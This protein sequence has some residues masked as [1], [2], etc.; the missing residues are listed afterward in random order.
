MH[1]FGRSSNGG[2]ILVLLA[3]G[4]IAAGVCFAQVIT[5]TLFGRITDP[6]GA[7]VPGVSLTAVNT[8][9]GREFTATTDATGNYSFLNL[10]P[11]EYTLK[12]E[13]SGFTTSTTHGIVLVVDQK[14][15]VDVALQVGQ[16]TA[17]VNVS[18][19]APVIDTTTASVGT[20]VAGQTVVA[21]PLNLR[22]YGSLALLSP[23]TVNDNGGFAS[24]TEGS[25]FAVSSYSANGSRT[26]SNNYLIDGVDARAVHFGSF[27]IEPDPDAIEEFKVQTNVYDAAFGTA[28]GSTIN[29]VTKSGTN[30]FH[31]TAYEFLRNSDMDSRNFFSQNQ[32]NIVTGQ[33]EPGTARAVLKRNQFGAAVGGP[34]RK[35]KTFFFGNYEGLRLIEGDVQSSLVPSAAEAQGNFGALLTGTD[36]NLCGTGGPAN[37]TYDTGQLFSPATESLY[38]CPSGTHSGSKVLVGTPLAS[39]VISSI[40][41][42]GAK[43]LASYPAPNLP[44]ANPNYLNQ[45]PETQGTELVDARVDNTFSAKDSVFVRYLY[46]SSNLVSP[47]AVPGFNTDTTFQ[48]QDA[49]IGWD[50]GFSPNMINELRLG[51]DRVDNK[52]GPPAYRAPGFEESFG[53]TG[54]GAFSGLELY[55]DFSITNFAGIGDYS[56]APL[57]IPSMV[58]VLGDNLSWYHGRHTFIFGADMDSWQYLAGSGPNDLQ[59]DFTYN[60]EFSSLASELPATTSASSLAD[61][62]LGY[63]SGAERAEAFQKIY[64]VGGKIWSYYAQDDIR[65]KSN[66]TI[67]AGLRWEFR[68]FPVDKNNILMTFVPT[69]APFSGTGNGILVSAYPAATLNQI[70]TQYPYLDSASG[71]CLIANST[72]TAQL[73]FTGRTARSLMHPNY[74]YFAPRG[75]FA[76]RPFTSDKLVLRGGG[77]MFFDLPIQ[78]NLT[79]GHNNPITSAE[80]TYTTAIGSPPPLTNGVPTTVENVFG[81]VAIP[82]I[83]D[84]GLGM[85]PW[86][87]YVYPTVY[88]WSLG[89]ESQLSTNSALDIEYVANHAIHLADVINNYNQPLPGIGALQPRRPYPDFDT[90]ENVASN[91]VSSYESLQAKYSRKFTNGLYMLASYTWSHTL[92][93]GEGDEGFNGGFGNGGAQNNNAPLSAMYG[94]SYIDVPQRLAVSYVYHLPFGKGQH[95]VNRGGVLGNAVGG[96]NVAGIITYQSGFPYSI[97]G[98]DYSNTGSTN[99]YPNRL[100]SGNGPNLLTEWFNTTCFSDTALQADL[101]ADTPTFGNAGRNIMT[102]PAYRDWDFVLFRNVRI[103]ERFNLDVRGELFNMFNNANF[104]FP[105][106]TITSSAFG[107]IT[108]ANTPRDIQLGLKL[109]F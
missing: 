95:F 35:D 29:L 75:G 17:T 14:G 47:S 79:F 60:G 25:P 27:S 1:R 21:L 54:L 22:Y 3:W 74:H 76:W 85:D 28:S 24:N 82:P 56:S 2:L 51:F 10:P 34:V 46:G 44:I 69:G 87:N 12:A 45:T 57:H 77:G 107:H 59:G 71:E 80:P 13:K 108:A 42:V 68:E 99:A 49:V 50:H 30:Q 19:S 100:C 104:S 81:G 78:N 38:T 8:G 18:G 97:R 26:S 20:I 64:E 15:E 65:V 43:V 41:P 86:P 91:N 16:V 52:V 109:H 101:A 96:W 36:T 106:E 53:I 48:G 84:Q 103:S 6:S 7:A 55:P 72:E 105:N 23:G 67:N 58:E 63:P 93:N 83:I 98:V 89:V 92:D 61:L 9:T 66:F 37:L 40:N 73:G 102:G 70:C 88:E 11:G 32:T 4:L 5:A 39:N 94:D 62:E 31:G 33:V 90:I